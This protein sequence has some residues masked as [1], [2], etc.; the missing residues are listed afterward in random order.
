MW[1][2]KQ[3]SLW[4]S[5]LVLVAPS[6]RSQSFDVLFLVDETGTMTGE[7]QALK[8]NGVTVIAPQAI[9]ALGDVAFGVAS[10]RDFP[11]APFGAVGDLP[12]VLRSQISTN[13]TAFNIG[14]NSL[15]AAGGGD[16]SE[17]GLHALHTAAGVSPLAPAWRPGA[18]R[19]IF[20]IGDGPSHDGD[21]EATYAA[22]C[23]QIGLLDAIGALDAT[24]IFVF[25]FDTGIAVPSAGLNSTGQA[26]AVASATGGTLS[27]V[28]EVSSLGS[29]IVAV[30]TGPLSNLPPPVP[31]LVPLGSLGL[32]LLLAALGLM[33]APLRP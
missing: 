10:Y 27:N 29:V 23:S 2:P 25:G 3:L 32:A 26:S 19:V 8:A 20:W 18:T 33:A 11:T 4:V 28:I 9:A 16:A 31:A 30:I 13:L 5:L 7:I 12:Y 14:L 21:L 24:D 15:T 22:C 6:A 17:A 1:N